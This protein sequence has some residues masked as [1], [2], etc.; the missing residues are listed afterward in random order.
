MIEFLRDG[1]IVVYDQ[2]L[3]F[4]HFQLER[5]IELFIILKNQLKDENLDDFYV[6]C[7]LH[8]SERRDCDNLP[9]L[10]FCV[11]GTYSSIDSSHKGKTR[12]ENWDSEKTNKRE[13]FEELGVNIT[14]V[15]KFKKGFTVMFGKRPTILEKI[16]SK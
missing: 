12:R 4:A 15:R 6:I 13:V 8:G 2:V 3:C 16:F 5:M 14:S 10:Q 7:P 9:H 1:S 11:T